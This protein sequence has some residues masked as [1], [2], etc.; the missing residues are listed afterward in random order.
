MYIDLEILYSKYIN[1][2]EIK[3]MQAVI[4]KLEIMVQEATAL[5][6]QAPDHLKA[7]HAGRVDQATFALEAARTTLTLTELVGV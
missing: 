4:R 5:G 6:E 3:I 7:Y 1:S 2:E